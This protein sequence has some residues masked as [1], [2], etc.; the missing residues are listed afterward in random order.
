M[1][2]VDFLHHE[3]P[4]TWAGVESSTLGAEGQRTDSIVATAVRCLW[5]KIRSRRVI[6]FGPRT[7]GVTEMIKA[8]EKSAAVVESRGHGHELL[9]DMSWVRA[10]GPLKAYHVEGLI[11]VK[12]LVSQSP[13]VGVV[14]KFEEGV[15][16][17][18]STSLFDRDSNLPGP[19]RFFGVRLK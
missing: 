13:P 16:D 7:S 14:W 6:S 17:Q 15:P 4:L 3:N 11:H 10:L 2:T 18:V 12:S 19:S 1:T 8:P 9:A 5:S